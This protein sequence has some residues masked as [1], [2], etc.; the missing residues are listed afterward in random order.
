[1]TCPY[2]L[3]VK[4]AL[5]S[6]ALTHSRSPRPLGLSSYW[7]VLPQPGAPER[8]LADVAADAHSQLSAAESLCASLS[9]VGR[10][11]LERVYERL[12]ENIRL[13]HADYSF[14]MDS[15]PEARPRSAGKRGRPARVD[16]FDPQG[17]MALQHLAMGKRLGLSTQITYR[18]CVSSYLRWLEAEGMQWSDAGPQEVERFLDTKGYRERSRMTYLTAIRRFYDVLRQC[19]VASTNPAR[20]LA[21][22]RP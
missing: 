5:S 16:D 4:K 6:L 2:Y 10:K 18:N 15:W 13:R 22:D 1:M 20:V 8:V 12:G 21:S 9:P 7:S 3:A 11:A 17:R 14:V 19:G